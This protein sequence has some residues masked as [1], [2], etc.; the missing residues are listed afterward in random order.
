MKKILKEDLLSEAKLD[1][2]AIIEL[3]DDRKVRLLA[4]FNEDANEPV[5]IEEHGS[6]WTIDIDA[7]IRRLA[8]ES[9]LEQ[10]LEISA[11]A[12]S[13]IYLTDGQSEQQILDYIGDIKLLKMD[14][15]A[16]Y[17]KLLF[18]AP[19]GEYVLC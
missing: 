15:P 12:S 3:T 13:S 14:G 7:A 4:L 8:G 5:Q 19:A 2:L 18:I 17:E 11:S 10:F 1:D 6:E 9:L 16:D